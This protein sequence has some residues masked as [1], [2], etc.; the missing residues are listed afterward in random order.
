MMPR[1][2]DKEFWR[3]HFKEGMYKTIRIAPAEDFALSPDAIYERWSYSVAAFEREK[4]ELRQPDRP[5]RPRL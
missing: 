4:R 2:S 5:R 3:R 1:M